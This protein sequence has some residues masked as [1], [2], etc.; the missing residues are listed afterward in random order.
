M[1]E[2]APLAFFAANAVES[3]FLQNANGRG[4]TDFD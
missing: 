4:V 1:I 2:R 3:D